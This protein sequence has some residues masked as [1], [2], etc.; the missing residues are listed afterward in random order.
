M[1]A[2]MFWLE[3]VL[4]M[5]Y[6]AIGLVVVLV[7]YTITET[8]LDNELMVILFWPIAIIVALIKIIICIFRR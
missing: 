7:Y 5:L 1:D 2:G 8:E 6:L 4:I 3:V